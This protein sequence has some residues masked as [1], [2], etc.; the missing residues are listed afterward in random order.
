MKSILRYTLLICAFLA[1][2]AARL[3]AQEQADAKKIVDLVWLKDGSKLSG[4]ILKWELERGMEFKLITGATMIIPKA[5]IDRVQ[6]SVAFAAEAPL[7]RYRRPDGPR[8]YSFREKGVYNAFSGFFNVSELGGA[9]LSYAI[10]YRWNKRVSAGI[11]V[12]METNDFFND[13]DLI[14]VYAE[15]RGFLQPK[16]SRHIMP[17]SSAIVSQ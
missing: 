11:G 17:S 12:A 5:D 6:Q 16:T 7:S 4:T 14:P 15:F 3:N 8:E 13:R 1:L 9:G 2:Q 10:G